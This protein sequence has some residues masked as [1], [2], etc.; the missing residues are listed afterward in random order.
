MLNAHARLKT[1]S[2]QSGGKTEKIGE[3]LAGDRQPVAPPENQ[4]GLVRPFVEALYNVHEL[5]EDRVR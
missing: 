2:R 4:T 3:K 5:R 1:R